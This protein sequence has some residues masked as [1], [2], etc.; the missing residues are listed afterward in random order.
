MAAQVFAETHAAGPQVL[1]IPKD[2]HGFLSPD[3]GVAIS[4][5]IISIAMVASTVFFLM[6]SMSIDQHWKTSMNVGA[7]VTLIAGVHYF[8]MREYWITIHESPIVY[9]YIDW[10]LT[11]PLQMVEF[12]LILQAAKPSING[13][14]FWRLLVGTVVM[15]AFGYMGE[16]QILN[17]WLGFVVGMAG[18]AYILFEIFAGEAGSIAGE[19]D[20][21][22][23]YVQQAFGTM[24]FIV[25]VG[26]SI[27][28]L[29]YFFG[30][31][32]NGVANAPLNLIYNLADFVNKIAFC[33]AIWFA[34]RSETRD[35]LAKQAGLSQ[36]LLA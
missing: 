13:G 32:M 27:Y 10:S 35:K 25:T 19:K 9:R 1:T 22:S 26:W 17:P 4:F 28:P 24:R 3:D 16:A 20:S 31:L 8:Y 14:M 15:L 18:W 6:E 33:L 30:Y 36:P 2:L 34:A 7:L 12:F 11:V 5:W 29:G 21:I 23:T